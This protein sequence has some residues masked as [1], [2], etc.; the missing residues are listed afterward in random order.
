[1]FCGYPLLYGSMCIQFSLTL[2]QGAPP[3]DAPAVDTAEQVY[4]SSLALL[5]VNKAQ[6]F[7]RRALLPEDTFSPLI[8]GLFE[9]IRKHARIQS[10]IFAL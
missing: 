1:M 9:K 8:C 10:G 2:F 7:C 4:I 5:K 3:S 6:L